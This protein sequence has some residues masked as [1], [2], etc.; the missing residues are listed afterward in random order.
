MKFLLG[1]GLG[2]FI[3]KKCGEIQEFLGKKEE[4][5]RERERESDLPWFW[6]FGAC[7]PYIGA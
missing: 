2:W 4:K 7:N 5:R 6:G 3:W 1:M